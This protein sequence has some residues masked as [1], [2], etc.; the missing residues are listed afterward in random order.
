MR[1]KK[2]CV[3]HRPAFSFA[4]PL[5][6][7]VNVSDLFIS[8]F[9]VLVAQFRYEMQTKSNVLMTFL[10]RNRM[11][12]RFDTKSVFFLFKDEISIIDQ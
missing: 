2:T 9:S 1:G 4:A 6:F 11:N 7:W 12:F 10:R 8:S 5:F 3:P